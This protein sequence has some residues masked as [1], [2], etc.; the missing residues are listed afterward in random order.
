MCANLSNVNITLLHMISQEVI[1]DINMLG[2]GM[3]F[4]VLSN[5]DGTLI[6]T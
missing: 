1:P 3:I 2:A 4:G 5:I 6:I